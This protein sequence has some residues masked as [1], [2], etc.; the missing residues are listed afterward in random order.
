MKKNSKKTIKKV[1]ESEK[2]QTVKKIE[3]NEKKEETIK[4]ETVEKKQDKPKLTN[5]KK[6][7][8]DFQTY[9]RERAKRNMLVVS[10]CQRCKENFEANDKIYIAN[11][12]EKTLIICS[13]CASK[14]MS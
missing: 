11:E 14:N 9:K 10:K 12:K 3:E 4:I 6:L 8:C 1:V 13:N 7:K 5:I 2:I